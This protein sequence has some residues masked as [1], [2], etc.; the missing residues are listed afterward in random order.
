M[1]SV[2]ETGFDSFDELVAAYYGEDFHESS[3]LAYEQRLSRN[4]R[5]PKVIAEVSHAANQWT[6]WEKRG[7]QE[8]ILKT[9]ESILAA[10]SNSVRNTLIPK[11][12]LLMHERKFS[13]DKSS[14]SQVIPLMKKLV[15]NEV[16]DLPTKYKHI[17]NEQQPNLWALTMTLADGEKGLSQQD[18]S[19][20][21]LA[22]VFL[23][24]LADQLPKDKLV[25]LI[26]ACL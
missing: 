22:I 12:V 9:S 14:I 19:S 5:L 16:S 1:K 2:E 8:E 13:A 4:R 17:L 24:Q 20:I 21:A 25:Q 23:M 15:Q 6:S 18:R 3:L 11:I 26:S 10:E 7:F